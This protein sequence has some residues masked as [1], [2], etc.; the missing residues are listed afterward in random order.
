MLAANSTR[1]PATGRLDGIAPP[2]G[3]GIERRIV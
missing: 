1:R 2:I 3:A